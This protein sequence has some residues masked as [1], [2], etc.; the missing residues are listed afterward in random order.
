M[1][2]IDKSQFDVVFFQ[3]TGKVEPIVPSRLTA[4]DGLLCGCNGHM[5]VEIRKEAL[6]AFQAVAEAE[7]L[8]GYFL[9]AP[10]EC[11]GK[12]CLAADIDADN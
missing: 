2:R 12:I 6:E 9:S 8:L 3:I 1:I 5:G 10:I 7:Y 11:T 4:H